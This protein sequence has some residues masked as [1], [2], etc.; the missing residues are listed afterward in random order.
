M[1]TRQDALLNFIGASGTQLLIPVYQ[2][3][4]SWSHKQCDVLWDDTL[5]AGNAGSAHFVG[6]VL[7]SVE[8]SEGEIEQRLDIIDGQ[9]R[10]VTMTLL[11]TA[12]RDHLAET[13]RTV[14]G[15]DAAAIEARYLHIGDTLKMELGRMDRL[16]AHAVMNKTELPGED[17]LSTNVADNYEHFKAKL[18]ATDEA[19]L[20]AL[21]RGMNLLLVVLAEMEDDDR[22]QLIFESLNA[23]G[24]PLTTADLVRNLLLVSA[25]LEDQ[26]RLYAEYWEPIEQLYGGDDGSTRLNAALHGWL[27]IT[28]PKLRVKDKDQVYSAFKL[29]LDTVENRNLEEILIGLKGFCETFAVKSAAAAGKPKQMDWDTK[30]SG[31]LI[32]EKKL[33]GS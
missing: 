16:T 25:S 13:G 18:D 17:D 12:L 29:Y 20:A 3:R 24:M 26:N 14:D 6:T 23:K 9:Q 4:Y 7:Y 10:T 2:R 22:P 32:S 28:A 21:W 5:R 33:F 8:E 1:K 27:A 11:L 31:Q 15:M 30:R 19:T